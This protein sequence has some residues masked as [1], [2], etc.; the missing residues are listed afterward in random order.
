[1]ISTKN[2]NQAL[3]S[4]G[5]NNLDLTMEDHFDQRHS[6]NKKHQKQKSDHD[7][8]SKQ[9]QCGESLYTTNSKIDLDERSMRKVDNEE[10][11]DQ[12]FRRAVDSLRPYDVICGRGSIPFN[13]IGNRR[14]R[15][16]ISL[17]V[18]SYSKCDGRDRKGLFI[19]SLVSTF[20]Q[21]IGV[22]FFKLKNGQLTQLTQRQI[23]QKVGR[24]LRDVLAFQESQLELEKQRQEDAEKKSAAIQTKQSGPCLMGHMTMKARSKEALSSIRSLIETERSA[25]TTIRFHNHALAPTLRPHNFCF[26]DS[27]ARSTLQDSSHT[28]T[29]HDCTRNQNTI[30]H[31]GYFERAAK[32]SLQNPDYFPVSA[33][34]R[35]SRQSSEFSTASIV[36]HRQNLDI[37]INHNL[38]SRQQSTAALQ[39]F[40]LNYTNYGNNNAQEKDD[41]HKDDYRF[42]H[43]RNDGNDSFDDDD[44]VPL[45]ID[46]PQGDDVIEMFGF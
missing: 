23:R 32:V 17:N 33:S 30:Q 18:N 10:D 27:A 7:N 38:F 16:L 22:R 37:E 40:V 28:P 39:N 29:F 44:L 6:T 12:Q 24:A 21:D 1:M 14:F 8:I 25:S 43:R 2:K 11:Q 20:E 9:P 31:I 15:I 5:H 4:I 35:Q 41:A 42:N 45:P 36:P 13:N 19:R 46:H 26:S 3:R 34:V